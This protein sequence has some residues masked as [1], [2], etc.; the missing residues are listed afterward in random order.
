M[1]GVMVFALHIVA[2]AVGVYVF[3]L[4]FVMRE[5]SEGEWVN[6]IDEFWVRVDD[7]RIAA[8]GLWFSLFSAIASKLTKVFNRIVGEKMISLRLVGVSGSLSFTSVFFFFALFFG[9]VSYFFLTYHDLIKQKVPSITKL[10]F[11]TGV[12]IIGF[13]LFLFLFLIFGILAALP[14]IFRSRVWVWLSCL[15]TALVLIFFIRVIY[16]HTLDAGG[17]AIFLSAVISLVSDVLLVAVIR[18]SL[19]WITGRVSPGRITGAIAVQ[20]LLVVITFLLPIQL[21][22]LR[23]HQKPQSSLSVGALMLAL[24]NFPTAV[25]S[26]CF[27]ASLVF[28]IIHHF[29]W[30]MIERLVYVLTRPEVLKKRVLVRVISAAIA[31]YG[32]Q[33]IPRAGFL[34]KIIESLN[35]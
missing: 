11:T 2:A 4:T 25:A 3:V 13:L 27:I 10:E 33:A 35:K 12:L 8:G 19:R 20:L 15:P 32:L 34:I 21:I 26:I 30:P 17:L 9:V 16:V 6:R 1:I 24:F 5:T 18:Q 22:I 28:L 7:R 31:F 29:T 23:A 14:M